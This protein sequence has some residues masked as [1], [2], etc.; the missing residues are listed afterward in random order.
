MEEN[1]RPIKE[2]NRISKLL[3]LSLDGSARYPVNVEKVALELT[4]S[5]NAD[6]ITM[7]QAG[8]MGKID[9]ILARHPQKDEWAIFYNQDI[10]H[11]G[12]TNFT[13]AH[14]LGHYF[15][16][17]NQMSTSRFECGESDMLDE[18]QNFSN[19][20]ME[21]NIFASNLLMPNHDFRTQVDGEPFSFDLMQHCTCRY[22]V[23]LT[24]VVLKWL[25]FSKR[26]AIAILSEDGF[27][28]WSKSNNRAFQSGRYY[29][30]RKECIEIPNRSS[31]FETRY[32]SH[33]RNGV[34]HKA[35]IWFPNAEA[36][37]FSIYSTEHEKTL[38]VLILEDSSGYHQENTH[39]EDEQLLVDTATQISRDF[40][41]R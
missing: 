29:A 27:M 11:K 17:R 37:E 26:E 33:A 30:T 6:P 15:V 9:G 21:A 14:E 18:N 7:V 41:Q 19:I 5:F 25:E 12:R 23:S 36:T 1:K 2:A 35:G 8:N 28:H 3:D 39:V 24:A 34:Q 22:D 13:L 4:P 38:T 16:H 40:R 10:A 31:A 32:T 20:E